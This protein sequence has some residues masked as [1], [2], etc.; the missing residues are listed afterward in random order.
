MVDLGATSQARLMRKDLERLRASGSRVA[1]YS[2]EIGDFYIGFSESLGFMDGA[3]LHDPLAVALAIDLSIATDLRPMHVQVETKGSLTYGET[4]A[5]RHH[6]LEAIEDAGDHY[7]ISSFPRVQPNARVPLS[8]DSE[9][10]IELFL[11]R[12]TR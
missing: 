10:F 12:L 5:N 8:V 11:R 7:R 3:D 6:Y 1:R 9:K 4:I 2:A